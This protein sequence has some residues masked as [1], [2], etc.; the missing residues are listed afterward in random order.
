MAK[1]L[2]KIVNKYIPLPNAVNI[3][4]TAQLIADLQDT[5]YEQHI[6][7]ASLDIENMY[8]NIPTNE[9]VQI[10]QRKCTEQGLEAGITKEIVK[11]TRMVIEQNYF[12][13]QH[14]CYIQQRGLAM[15]P[16]SSSML[17]EIF[18]KELE[19]TNITRILT[20]ITY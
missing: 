13:F 19:S 11:V 4:N 15:A 5:P 2:N 18:I 1:L 3:K 7:L 17:S 12:E 6:K 16:P 20:K 10:I 8:P 9:L 14:K